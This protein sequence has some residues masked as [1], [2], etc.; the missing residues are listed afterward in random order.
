MQQALKYFL[1]KPRNKN[2]ILQM[3]K[4]V[5]KLN[6]FLQD[7]YSSWGRWHYS[8]HHPGFLSSFKIGCDPLKP[9]TQNKV[10]VAN[11]SILS[12]SKAKHEW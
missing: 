6:D 2:P 8:Y 4:Q 12:A 11:Q 10:F 9:N 5:E 1:E 7:T 3:G